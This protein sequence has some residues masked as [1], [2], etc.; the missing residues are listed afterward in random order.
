MP[1]ANGVTNSYEE[2]NLHDEDVP[3]PIAAAF[4]IK[5]DLQKGWV[6]VRQAAALSV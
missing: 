6:Y 4:L 2:P 3:P 5:F 1:E